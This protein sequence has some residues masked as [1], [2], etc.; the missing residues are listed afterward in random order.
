MYLLPLAACIAHFFKDPEWV[1][2][3]KTGIDISINGLHSSPAVMNI[4]SG[5]VPGIPA[6]KVLHPDNGLYTL[7]ADAAIPHQ[8]ATQGVTGVM[9]CYH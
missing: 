2:L 8:R 6:G 7:A 1:A 4:N 5:A 9:S 3:R